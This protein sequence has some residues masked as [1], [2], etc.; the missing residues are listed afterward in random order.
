MGMKNH[1]KNIRSKGGRH[2]FLAGLLVLC[3]LLNYM[4]IHFIPAYAAEFDPVVIDVG[5]QVSAVIDGGVLTL[6]G[7]GRTDDYTAE[8]APFLS[9]AAEIHTL[10]IEDGVTY[11]GAYLFYG[12]SGLGGELTLPGN[13]TGFGDYAFSG[14]GKDNAPAFTI[15][16]NLFVSAEITEPAETDAGTEPPA[17]NVTVPEEPGNTEEPENPEAVEIPEVAENIKGPENLV[18]TAEQADMK[19]L[20]IPAETRII[21]QQEIVK[22]ETLFA[23][24]QTGFAICA[25]DNVSFAAGAQTAG[26]QVSD[27]SVRLTL[28]DLTETELPVID[29]QVCLPECPEEIKAVHG[30]D[31]SFRYEFAGWSQSP[32]DDAKNAVPAGQYLPTQGAGQ[33][34]LYSIWN[35]VSK[36]QAKTRAAVQ[37]SADGEE[38]T[39][40]V[41][42]TTG[43]DA[44]E[45]TK[46]QPFKT[47]KKA[48]EK[49]KEENPN[50]TV[51]TNRIVLLGD[52]SMKTISVNS[53][54][55]GEFLGGIPVAVTVSGNQGN[56]TLAGGTGSEPAINLC[57][58]LKLENLK[59]ETGNHIYAC[60]HD[61]T[62]GADID[63]KTIYLYGA[64]SNM[65]SDK[66]GNIVV[67]SGGIARI[68]G[69]VRS[70]PNVDAGGKEAHITVKG[71]AIVTYIVAGSA[72]GSMSNADVTIDIDGGNVTNIVGGNQGFNAIASDYQGKTVINVTDGKVGNIYGAG[73]GR[74]ESVPTFL[75]NLDINIS[76]GRVDN[77]YGAGSAAYVI[78]NNEI[79]SSVDI[80][81][82]GGEVGN[83]F[84]AGKGNEREVLKTENSANTLPTEHFGSLTGNVSIGVSGSAIVTGN[85]YGSGAGDK[86][87]N[88]NIT[89]EEKAGLKKNAYLKGNAKIKL[90]PGG[91]VKGNIYGGGK[92]FEEPDYAEC[93]R[94]ESG[95]KVTVEI[96][97]GMVEGSVFGGGENGSVKEDT[98]VLISGGTVQGNVYGGSMNAAVGGKS[99]VTITNGTVVS[100]VYGGALGSPGKN[101]IKGGATVNM[102]G[103]WVKGNLY[104]GSENSDDGEQSDENSIKDLVFVN[105]TGGTVDRS[106]FG[107]GYMGKVYGST[108]VHVGIGAP[109]KCKYYTGEGKEELPGLKA[110]ALQIGGSVY[111]GGDFGSGA[112]YDTITITGTSH[113]YID[114]EGYQ[115]GGT[116][117]ENPEMNI[118]GGVFGSG[119]SCDA[120][121]TRLVTL[122]HYGERAEDTSSGKVDVTRTIAAIQR[123]DRVLLL[124]SHV[125]LSGQSDIANVDETALYSLNR[126]GDHQDADVGE[127][128]SGLVLQ[129]NSTIILD[130]EAIGLGR[131]SSVDKQGDAVTIDDI[132]ETPNTIRFDAGTVF[133]V[134]YTDKTDNKLVYGEVNGYAYMQAEDR[135]EAYAY[136]RINVGA[137]KNDGGFAGPD[138]EALKYY[139]VG[140]SYRYWQMK[141]EDAVSERQTVLTA[142]ELKESD[143]GYVDESFAVASGSI[144]LPQTTAETSYTI[145][146][147]TISNE[148]GLNLAEAARNGTGPESTWVT[149]QANHS[150][151]SGTVIDEAE[152]KEKIKNNPLTDVGLY[153]GTGEGF[154]LSGTGKVVS[155][156]AAVSNDPNTIIGEKIPGA[157]E[158][159]MPQI[160][161]YLTY[162]NQNITVSKTLGE[163]QIELEGIDSRNN[164]TTV[165]MKV[166]IV[167]KATALSDQSVDLY[168]TQ[169][170]SYTG[171]MTVP[172][173]TG[174]TLSLTKV[175][176][177]GVADSLV[178]YDS[179][180][181][182]GEQFAVS[183]QTVK[184][185]GWKTD[186]AA[187]CDLSSFKQGTPVKIGSTDSR[188]PA[189][190]EFNLR[191]NPAF[192]AKEAPDA[193]K[194]TFTDADNN[195]TV[196][197]L[198][199]HWEPSI[200]SSVQ[201]MAG[202]IY[203][204]P[205][206]LEGNITISNKSAVTSRFTV[207]SNVAVGD[208][209]L[210]LKNTA[211]D[212]ID[213]FPAGTQMTLIAG[214]NFYTYEITG[215]EAEKKIRLADFRTMWDNDSLTGNVTNGSVLTLITDL[216]TAGSSISAGSYSIRLRQNKS[217]DSQSDFFTVDNSTPTAALDIKKSGA[218]EYTFNISAAA[219]N[220]TRFLGGV[221]AELE[222]S[223]KKTFPV[224]TV[225][226]Y[227][228]GEKQYT[229]YPR[230]GKVCLPLS[231]T[232]QQEYTMSLSDPKVIEAGENSFHVSIV[233]NGTNA[234]GGSGKL[235]E[236][237]KGVTIEEPPVCGLSVSLKNGSSRIVNAG[238]SIN[239]TANYSISGPAQTMEVITQ[240]KNEGGYG[241]TDNWSVSGVTNIS[242]TGSS[243]ITVIVP[244]STGQ[245]TYRL[246]FRLGGQEVPYNLI[247]E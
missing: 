129:D 179:S 229:Y 206:N 192:A 33:M 197:T 35:K 9:Y 181:L 193:L 111:A 48:A 24:G 100:S 157:K 17:E 110:S 219:Y 236:A 2:R 151:T 166:R 128:G 150:G 215:T 121:S 57:G 23:Q 49:L 146:S 45:G 132:K 22:P 27:T 159:V 200:V 124:N 231:G 86:T 211:G 225:F 167:T 116:N 72:S 89:A 101:L 217:A 120:G 222:L 8:T 84:A 68:I 83:I 130:S 117:S 199:I 98:N 135:A 92:G 163:V 133:R 149:S 25:A 188:Y 10:V 20:E 143:T 226:Y 232:G 16:R 224:S 152:E 154:G 91:T 21:T 115:T 187:A 174:R 189:E 208:L 47:M 204:E 75:G 161:F 5:G 148:G 158:N 214:E 18:N 164:K 11:I 234:G 32:S 202:R 87:V 53:E 29:G 77:I 62:F 238:S 136:A 127:L 218:L 223:D 213:Q 169:S 201:V 182:T 82:T 122:D 12:L 210:E 52:Y 31:E 38:Y 93:A 55:T 240:K 242:G 205:K 76:G 160:Q 118:S 6:S 245:G 145:K 241:K 153:M 190:I 244:E 39:V 59:L 79:T 14:D 1:N 195:P 239:L 37:S 58:D 74:N 40:Y 43:D 141:K 4:S 44:W 147:V 178:A 112:D 243:D 191:N 70:Y 173:G 186:M 237:D 184:S 212:S 99:H 196:I 168:A 119:A 123:A 180:T 227:T 41:A 104:G 105:L 36:N 106:I 34:A 108:H 246:L 3:L 65:I 131:F 140:T 194:I 42:Q 102:T 139:E 69:Y 97:G 30:E 233:A 221:S 230:G 95:S 114:G 94:V 103:G 66:I 155:T 134:A 64:M 137:G 85:I 171:R 60:G 142:Q 13:I 109:G 56:E 175:D 165:N 209:W 54:K 138:D 144:E 126:I 198:N 170:G 19:E 125:R 26:Y 207:G 176:A 156:R 177:Q 67:E 63:S 61:I 73:T 46:E 185:Q 96:A 107:G 235:T 15:I 203:D 247:V 113:V 228:D 71:T 220:D 78:S 28:D 7:Q 80:S 81:L 51:D 88:T 172:A 183:M 90:S 216:S 162:S 50:G